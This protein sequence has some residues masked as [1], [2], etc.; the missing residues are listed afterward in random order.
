MVG[1]GEQPAEETTEEI[2]REAEEEMDRAA[3]LAREVSEKRHNS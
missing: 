2:A 1:Q 3:R